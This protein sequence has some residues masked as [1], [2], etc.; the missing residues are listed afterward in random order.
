MFL[1]KR[2]RILRHNLY[3]LL[4]YCGRCRDVGFSGM[5]KAARLEPKL[6]RPAEA[7][8]AARS[9]SHSL[10][11]IV[12]TAAEVGQAHTVTKSGSAS[13]DLPPTLPDVEKGFT[14]IFCIWLWSNTSS[15]GFI[16]RK[17]NLININMCCSDETCVR[18]ADVDGNLLS[19]PAV[20]PTVI[21]LTYILLSQDGHW[22]AGTV[23]VSETQAS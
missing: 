4:L 12:Y 8:P 11:D 7:W 18:M 9:S 1:R 15:V 6:S 3:P 20:M 14:R 13:S 19:H 2:F 17:S 22:C 16:W 10:V 23:C 21:V 5:F